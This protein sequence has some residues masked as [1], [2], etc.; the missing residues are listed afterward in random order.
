MGGIGQISR[1]NENQIIFPGIVYDNQ[2]PMMLGRLRVL[3]ETKNY[4]DIIKSVKDWNEERDKWSGKDPFIFI[5]LL[6]FY[7]NQI[8]KVGEYVH[9]IYMNKNFE[10]E[11]KFYVQ[12]PFSSPL[13]SN[14]ESYS[15]SKKYLASGTRVAETFS[16]K[17]T[18]G[19][20][21][22]I[23]SFGVFPEPGDNAY[24][25]RGTADLILKEDEVLLRA[26]KVT[27]FSAGSLPKGNINRAFLQ[28]SQFKQRKIPG[29]TT[30]ISTE[31]ELPKQV[32]KMIVWDIQNLE[33]QFDSFTGYIRL[34]QIINPT[35]ATT[36][37]NFKQSTITEISEGTNYKF[38]GE[39]I[40]FLGDKFNKVVR[41]MNKFIRGLFEGRYNDAIDFRNFETNNF[42]F[43][44]TPSK[45]TFNVGFKF[46]ANTSI[47]DYT[48]YNNFI[49]FYEKITVQ[50]GAEEFGFFL[51]S[52]NDG[53]NPIFGVETETTEI[54]TVEN[55]ILNTSTT[56]SVMGAQ[57]VYLLSHETNGPKGQ[58]ILQDTLYGIPS[59]K[60]EEGDNNIEKLTYPVVRG[61]KLIE[62][63]RKLVAFV[64]DHVHGGPGLI[65]V[66]LAGSNSIIEISTLLA[67]AENT[68]LNQNIRIN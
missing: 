10:Y 30:T 53:G 51:V 24:L 26:G 61:D 42:P 16:I 65:P 38:T 54:K 58:I 21:Q 55:R 56:Y 64:G 33:N 39:E 62:V 29:T 15:G 14:Y 8:P 40:R 13:T 47:T 60:F 3:P 63:L 52:R 4:Q 59:S 25:G 6:P 41:N 19:T 66:P 43:V 22:D 9:I 48:E 45:E 32:Q 1:Q 68:I 34:Y 44:V 46:Q 67:Q 37:A 36:T 5:P 50:Q 57:K 17:N 35:E 12:G 11:N 23:A 27:T 7:L 49:N 31:K 28:L 2:D 18:N 20:Y